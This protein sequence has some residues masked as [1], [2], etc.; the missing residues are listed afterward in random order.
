MATALD[1]RCPI[2]L[3]SW[4][5]ASYV[6][7]CLHQFCFR[8]IQRWAESKPECPL[9]KRTVTSIVHSVRADD[10]FK[11]VTIAASAEA[12]DVGHA[13]APGPQH[14]SGSQ[15]QAAGPLPGAPVG[16][17]HP[18]TWAFIFRLYP[19]VL[20]PLLPW[21]RRELEQLLGADIRAASEAQHLVIS[22]LRFFG[23]DEGALALL[24]RTSLR[25]HTAG[26]VRQLIDTSAQQ[27][28]GEVHR[29]LGR[30]EPHAAASGPSAS[31]EGNPAPGPVPSRSP[32]AANMEEIPSTSAA[33]ALH[34]GPSRP[35]S[36]QEEPHEEQGEAAAGPSTASRVR[37]RSRR[38]PQR[39]PRRRA[40][41]SQDSLPTKERPPRC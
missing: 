37:D 17:L 11:E 23:L 32:E 39:P 34:G 25:R 33:V 38:T 16:G 41:S 31:P 21:L 28:S 4:D 8:C 35:L 1:S 6:L 29:L 2:C 7:P 22:S 36:A 9:C 15:P 20:Q 5:D 14:P 3:D 13:A 26:F 24:L 19:Q 40:T 10:K 18:T 30:E 12:L 27:C